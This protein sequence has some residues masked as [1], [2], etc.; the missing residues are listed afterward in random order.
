LLLPAL[1]GALMFLGLRTI[2]YPTA[3]LPTA[4]ANATR[5][6]GVEP[7]FD[8][9][10][11]VGFDVSGYEFALDPNGD[12]STGPTTYWGVADIDAAIT[13]LI[14]AG[15]TLRSG[16]DDVGDEIRVATVAVP[17]VGVIGVIQNPHFQAHP[18]SGTGP[19]R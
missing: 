18:S 10:F 8:Q 13:Q 9:P 11:Y 17:A 4:K 2:I 16:I 14:S 15:A 12:A 19:G 7:Y 5:I 3:D 1:K 6:L